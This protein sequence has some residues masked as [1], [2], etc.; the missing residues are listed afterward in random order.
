MIFSPLLL[1]IQM[2]RLS[3]QA[4]QLFSTGDSDDPEKPEILDGRAGEVD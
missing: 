3:A 1:Q 2:A 4:P